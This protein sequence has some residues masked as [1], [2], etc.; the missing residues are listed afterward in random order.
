[1]TLSGFLLT[2]KGSSKSGNYGHSGRPGKVG[3]SSTLSFSRISERIWQGRQSG[4][5]STLSK[6]ETGDIAEK[7]VIQALKDHLGVE[8]TTLNVGMNNAPIDLGAPGIAVEV[9]GGL[10]SNSSSAQTWRATIGEPGKAEK[11]LIAQMT[12]EEKKAHNQ[13]KSQKILERKQRLLDELSEMSGG[14]VKGYTAAVI[15]SPDGKKGDV[16]LFENFHLNLRWSQFAVDK[17]HIG[18]YESN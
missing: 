8:L 3:G 6:L 2:L 13:Y 11:A 1:M 12:P 15:M 9:K 4:E 16:Y 5:Q 7:M 18:S 14:P 10:T 17:Y